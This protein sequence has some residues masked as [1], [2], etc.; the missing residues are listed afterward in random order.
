MATRRRMRE[1]RPPVRRAAPRPAAPVRRCFS[2]CRPGTG[3]RRGS[4]V[5]ASISPGRAWA[6]NAG[7]W[8]SISGSASGASWLSI[9]SAIRVPIRVPSAAAVTAPAQAS[10]DRV[11]GRRV[12]PNA[13][14]PE[15][16]GG[17]GSVRTPD[18]GPAAA[19]LASGQAR[20]AVAAAGAV[21]CWPA[22]RPR[23]AV[24]RTEPWGCW[25]ADGPR[26]AVETAGA[27]PVR[28]GGGTVTGRG[29]GQ[30]ARACGAGRGGLRLGEAARAVVGNHGAGPKGA[31]APAG[32]RAFPER[33]GPVADSAAA[34]AL[35]GAACAPA[36]PACDVTR[37]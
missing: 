26:D 21:G 7:S 2:S 9:T 14:H 27:L 12:P 30:E 1:R 32:R 24:R 22:D 34:L 3:C 29:R 28:A 20:D 5:A 18:S 10:G 4:C 25:P 35:R 11:A 16:E 13:G 23:H 8:R 36:V 33:P 6:L 17:A 37:V 15:A 31:A 19:V